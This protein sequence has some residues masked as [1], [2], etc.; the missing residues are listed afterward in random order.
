MEFLAFS[1]KCHLKKILNGTLGIQHD[2]HMQQEIWKPEWLDSHEYYL[3][4]QP[5]NAERCISECIL[6][7][8]HSPTSYYMAD[9]VYGISLL[10]HV[11]AGLLSGQ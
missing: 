3:D 9:E 5:T 4:Q 7:F 6:T 10:Q 8:V 11:A 1:L 2:K